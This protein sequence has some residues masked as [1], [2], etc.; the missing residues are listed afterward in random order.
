MKL[1]QILHFS[2]SRVD[3]CFVP[4]N[5]GDPVESSEQVDEVTKFLTQLRSK[6][7]QSCCE[8]FDKIPDLTKETLIE[9]ISRAHSE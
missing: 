8:D 7:R 5:K 3:I 4:T 2:S 9:A 1:D 6:L